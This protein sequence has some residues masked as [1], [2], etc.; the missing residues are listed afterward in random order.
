MIFHTESAKWINTDMLRGFFIGG[1]RRPSPE[2]HLMLLA[3]S[4]HVALPV[5][6]D[7]KNVVGFITAI[8]GGV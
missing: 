7:T 4:D 2:T 3:N 1:G 5:H 6:D 8:S